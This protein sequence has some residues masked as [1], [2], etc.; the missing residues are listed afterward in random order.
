[1]DWILYRTGFTDQPL[2]QGCVV[3]NLAKWCENKGFKRITKIDD[4]QPGDI[5]FVR[6]DSAGVPQHVFMLA[7]EVNNGMA[8]R[9]D[10]G[11]DRRIVSRQ[12]TLEPVSYD[13]A[14]FAFAYRPIAGKSNNVYGSF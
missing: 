3:S 2:V 1:M 14:P 8:L 9:Y 6:P 5:I 11:S 12:P 4:L 13:D 10:H 7:S